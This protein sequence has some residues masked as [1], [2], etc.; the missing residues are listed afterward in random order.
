MRFYLI[1]YQNNKFLS[2]K[3]P[4]FFINSSVKKNNNKYFTRKSS[5]SMFYKY[6]HSINLSTVELILEACFEAS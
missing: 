1:F 5:F 6:W 3:L 2:S 4:K